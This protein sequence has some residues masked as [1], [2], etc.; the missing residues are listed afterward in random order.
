MILVTAFS[1]NYLGVHTP[2]YV[3]VDLIIGSVSL[4]IAVK[5]LDYLDMN[6]DKLG[7]VMFFL[8]AMGALTL[9]YVM[10]KSYP[11]DYVDGKLL[12][13]PDR[14]TIDSWGDAGGLAVFALMNYIEQKYISFT[15]TGWNIKGVIISAIGLIP[16]CWMIGNLEGILAGF[17]NPHVRKLV[18]QIIFFFYVMI[19]WPLVMK[20]FVKPSK[21]TS[22]P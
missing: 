4:Y 3:L 16:V 15:S 6:P 12:V 5:I 20:L 19:L 17:F 10:F 21:S 7:I 2:Q 1:R 8:G 18:F 14:M 11:M 22:E 13:D 9:V